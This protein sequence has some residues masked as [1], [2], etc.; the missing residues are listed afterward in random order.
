[1]SSSAPHRSRSSVTFSSSGTTCGTVESPPSPRQAPAYPPRCH[2]P[3][4]H[5]P[6]LCPP[7][8][9]PDLSRI[10]PLI[11][12]LL[13]LSNQALSPKRAPALRSL[14]LHGNGLR[15][16]GLIGLLAG[17]LDGKGSNGRQCSRALE[18]LLLHDN[19][20]DDKVRTNKKGEKKKTPLT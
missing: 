7:T 9:H 19:L 10:F 4:C 12:F 5:P 1:M 18:T 14:Y 3:S 2:T 13:H 20:I 8:H 17:L 11:L 16:G 6:P 15:S